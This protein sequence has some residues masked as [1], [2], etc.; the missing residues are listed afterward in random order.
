MYFLQIITLAKQK[1]TNFKF[2]LNSSFLIG[3]NKKKTMWFF[4]QNIDNTTKSTKSIQISKKV[5]K[6]DETYIL[7]NLRKCTN[8]SV[9]FN[10]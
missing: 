1:K 5:D 10:F 6:R 7:Y 9:Y 4:Y 2:F 3:V 8:I